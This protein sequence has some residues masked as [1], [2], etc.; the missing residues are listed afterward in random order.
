M[1]KVIE[2]DLVRHMHYRDNLGKRT[3]SR[4]TGLHRETIKK[5]K[6]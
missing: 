3:I 1:K 2:Y 4:Q 5:M 6:W